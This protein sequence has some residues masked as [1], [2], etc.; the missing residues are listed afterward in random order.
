[1]CDAEYPCTLAQIP[2][3]AAKQIEQLQ[4]QLAALTLP[5]RSSHGPDVAPSSPAIVDGPEPAATHVG[6]RVEDRAEAEMETATTTVTAI[7]SPTPE[8]SMATPS[9]ATASDGR[10]PTLATSTP[11][12]QAFL[13]LGNGKLL[14][15]S[16]KSVCDPPAISFAKDIPK[17]MRMWDDSSEAWSPSE[18]VLHIQGEPIALKHWPD[19]YRYG[20]HGQWAGTKKNWAQWRVSFCLC[21][22]FSF[23][24]VMLTI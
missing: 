5:L 14:R 2:K 19:V 1:M 10:P 7:D 17:L 16:R 20:K 8:E 3:H 4:A 18:A 12:P 21:A 23:C 9:A 13:K 6:S 24:D 15:F 22:P 11:G